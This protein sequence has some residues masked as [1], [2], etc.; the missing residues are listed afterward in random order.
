MWRDPTEVV[1]WDEVRERLSVV[2]DRT[3][4]GEL[5][6]DLPSTVFDRNVHI[7]PLHGRPGHYLYDVPYA[8]T[9]ELR[10]YDDTSDTDEQLAELDRHDPPHGPFRCDLH[11]VPTRDGETTIFTSLHDGGRQVYVLE[12]D[13]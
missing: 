4:R 8:E 3:P 6:R 9:V 13:G 2:G 11:P 5:L 10:S 1:L 7:H 12:R